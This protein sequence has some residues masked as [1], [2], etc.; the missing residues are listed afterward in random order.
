MKHVKVTKKQC[1]FAVQEVYGVHSVNDFTK[2]CYELAVSHK[3]FFFDV[4]TGVVDQY[5]TDQEK[6]KYRS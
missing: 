6:S 1:L 3:D 2:K 5:Y 4:L